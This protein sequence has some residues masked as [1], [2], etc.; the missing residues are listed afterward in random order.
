V[1]SELIAGANQSIVV[2]L[3]SDTGTEVDPM[4]LYAEVA[5]DAER[6]SEAGQRIV[7]MAS[8]PVRHAGVL[9]GRQGSGFETKIAVAVVYAG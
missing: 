4:A 9:M 6:R 8:V 5:L 2:Y 3:S 1:P 7:S